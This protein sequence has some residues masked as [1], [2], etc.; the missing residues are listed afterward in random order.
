MPSHGIR[1]T[2]ERSWVSDLAPF[3]RRDVIRVSPDAGPV[4]HGR[5]NAT[6]QGRAVSNAA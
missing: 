4:V 1:R 3:P 5:S 6:K 2:G